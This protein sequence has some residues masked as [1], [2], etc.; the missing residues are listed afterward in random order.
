MTSCRACPSKESSNFE[1]SFPFGLD[2]W[3]NLEVGNFEIE[4]G[5]SPEFEK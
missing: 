4:A 5:V 3:G 1:Y 2:A